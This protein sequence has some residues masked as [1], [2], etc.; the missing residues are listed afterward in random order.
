M[1]PME[2]KY[3]K[4]DQKMIMFETGL[5][6]PE[7]RQSKVEVLHERMLLYFTH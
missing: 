3:A 5:V 6:V 2:E 1:N 7:M 4:V